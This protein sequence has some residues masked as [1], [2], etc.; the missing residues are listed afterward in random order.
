MSLPSFIE[1]CAIVSTDGMLA[2]PDGIMPRELIIP[3]DQR[4][5]ESVVGRADAVVHGR[6]S[7]EQHANSDRRRRLIVT[8]RV[9]ALARDPENA[10][11]W[12][13][14]P[15]GASFEQAWDALAIKDGTLAVIGATAVFGMF[16]PLYDR[17][18]LSRAAHVRLP[19]GRPVFP[20][21]PA[22]TPEQVLESSG[23]VPGPQ[24]VLDA[25]AGVTLVTFERKPKG[26]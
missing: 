2:G 24:R 25:A 22:R 10:K 21:V 5:F 16:L 11:A 13:W 23:L 18:H 4:F 9:P 7:Q 3:A 6:H 19:G 1:A 14:N 15:A 26:T 12:L 17:F 20:Q 8:H